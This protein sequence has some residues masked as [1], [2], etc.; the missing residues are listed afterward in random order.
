MIN[1]GEIWCLDEYKIHDE[2]PQAVK[3][4]WVWAYVIAGIGGRVHIDVPFECRTSDEF[5]W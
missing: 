4:D 1:N 2:A 3:A 5:I